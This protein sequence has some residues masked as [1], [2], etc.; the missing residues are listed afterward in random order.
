MHLLPSEQ[1][2]R[3][4]ESIST[5][6]QT[7][8]LMIEEP[9]DCGSHIR[10]DNGG[11]YHEFI[12]LKKDDEKDFIKTDTTCELNKPAE[13]YECDDPHQVIRDNADWL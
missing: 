5:Y 1:K 8:S 13:W 3:I 2:K 7:G 6:D 9:C 10:H 11:N 4:E 12:K